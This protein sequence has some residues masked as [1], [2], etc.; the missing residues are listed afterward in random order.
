MKKFIFL[1]ILILS[2]LFVFSQELNFQ[3]IINSDRARTQEKDVFEDMKTTF[4]QYLNGRNWTNDEFR[5]IERI[6]GSMLITIN[7]MPQV[8]FYN[9]TVQVQVVRPIYGTN[10]ESMTFNFID[11]NWTFEFLQNQPLEFN[12]FSYLN[13]I[14]SLLAYYANMAL[15]IDYDSFTLRGGDPYFEIANGIVNNAQQSNRP[16]WNQSPTD[17]RNRYWL[18]NDIYTSSVFA[19]IREAIY[20]YHRKGMDLLNKD[21]NEAYKN[22]LEAI[23]KVE[24]A[25][26]AQPNS[27]F[28]I[29]FMDAKGDEISKIFKNAP[30]EI[31]TEAVELLLKVDPNNAR[32]YNDLLKG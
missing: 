18:I 23:K 4:E 31:R 7:D 3:V 14:S 9:A 13:N 20:L 21:P 2:P 17:R 27:I 15:G 12:R 6:K 26:T 22:M 16:G 29:S 1:T 25:N 5:P 24:E 10:Y 28:T 11:R 32:K 8:G 30:L 19:P